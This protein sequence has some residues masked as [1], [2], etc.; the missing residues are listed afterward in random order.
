MITNSATP[1]LR[2]ATSA[3]APFLRA[4]YRTTRD[5]ELDSVPWNDEQKSAFCNMQ[6]DLQSAGYAQMFPSA[7][8]LVICTPEGEPAGRLIK[9]R[10]ED[11]VRLIDIA[12]LPAWRRRGW[13]GL[14]IDAL[15]QEAAGHGLPL[16]LTVERFNPALDLYRRMGF[17]TDDDEDEIYIRMSWRAA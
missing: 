12:L 6:F 3:D 14:L 10:L 15:M 11:A 5:P 13:G 8:Y 1:R 16:Q 4:L 7:E 2:P 17:A 9:A